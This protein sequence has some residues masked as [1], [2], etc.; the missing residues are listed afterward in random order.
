MARTPVDL[1]GK[2]RLLDDPTV[3]NTGVGGARV[4]DMGAPE[5]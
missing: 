4:V 1:A 2:R 5:R 3:P